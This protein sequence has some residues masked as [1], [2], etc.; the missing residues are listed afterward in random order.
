[1][2]RCILL[3]RRGPKLRRTLSIIHPGPSSFQHRSSSRLC[4]SLHSENSF[5]REDYSIWNL[6]HDPESYSCRGWRRGSGLRCPRVRLGVVSLVALLRLGKGG[7]RETWYQAEFAWIHPNT[8]GRK[9]SC[10]PRK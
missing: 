8:R 7:E 1:M 10:R 4:Q 5:P 6:A 2:G 9:E 3:C